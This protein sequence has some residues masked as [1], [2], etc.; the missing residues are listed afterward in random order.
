MDHEA[1]GY[2]FEEPIPTETEFPGASG[3]TIMVDMDVLVSYYEQTNA[4]DSS[5]EGTI[6]YSRK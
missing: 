4:I 6:F 5:R 1:E 2:S 3:K